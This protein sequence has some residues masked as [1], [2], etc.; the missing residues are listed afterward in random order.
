[1]QEAARAGG[2]A[3]VLVTPDDSDV[4]QLNKRIEHSI[5]AAPAQEGERWKDAGYYLLPVFALLLLPFF[6][7][8]SAVSLSS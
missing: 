3:L 1:M 5:A 8:G 6:R 2:G 7:R 4:R